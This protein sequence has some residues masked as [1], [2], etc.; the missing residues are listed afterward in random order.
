MYPDLYI[1]LIIWGQVALFILRVA[2]GLIFIVHGWPKIK[3]LKK[4]R[5]DFTSMGF[6]PGFLWGTLA[7]LLETI[8]GLVLILGMF[9]RPVAGLFA[10]EMLVTTV[11]KIKQGK[12]FVN[13]YVF[14]LLLLATALILLTIGGSNYS[15][16][17]LFL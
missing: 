5:K 12:G 15:L 10:L 9:V 17:T 1:L 2:L 11:W 14:D 4:T 13:G 16:Q 3:D 7:A 8:G 6:R